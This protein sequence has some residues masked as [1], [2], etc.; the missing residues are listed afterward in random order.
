MRRRAYTEMSEQMDHLL[1]RLAGD[2]PSPPA[3]VAPRVGA[4]IVDLREEWRAS[5]ALR[6][7][8]LV[9]LVGAA[10]VGAVSGSMAAIAQQPSSTEFAAF[11]PSASLAPST[12]LD[13]AS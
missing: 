6:P 11:S 5:R 8:R 10:G 1:A 3:T 13:E 4:R 12:L 9:L 2:A 7:L